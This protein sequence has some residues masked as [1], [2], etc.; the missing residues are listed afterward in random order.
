M[1]DLT[2]NPNVV[3]LGDLRAE[4]AYCV[5][6]AILFTA[7]GIFCFFFF[8]G[9]TGMRQELKE[10]L[11]RDLLTARPQ[12]AF[13]VIFFIWFISIFW[14]YNASLGSRFFELERDGEGAK[15]VWKLVYHYPERVRPI[16][17]EQVE[18]WTGAVV[19]SGRTMRH[20]LVMKLKN[21]REFESAGIH[22][23]LFKERAQLLEKW[24]I[25]VPFEDPMPFSGPTSTPATNSGTR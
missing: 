22:P 3:G 8:T 19:W 12:S 14:V 10:A 13:F 2:G 4:M 6:M 11:G 23:T 7:V 24:G 15:T 20:A 17:A 16:P 5:L 21:G 1:I 9:R 18:S 25:K